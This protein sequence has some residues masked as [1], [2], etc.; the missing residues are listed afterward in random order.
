M[1][2]PEMKILVHNPE[3]K[4]EHVIGR[5]RLTKPYLLKLFKGVGLSRYHTR[6]IRFQPWQKL[7]VVFAYGLQDLFRLLMYSMAHCKDRSSVVVQ[8]EFTLLYYSFLSPFYR[9]T[10]AK[11][12]I[13][14]NRNFTYLSP[15]QVDSS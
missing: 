15:L 13:V 12:E 5:D 4:I 14:D 9:L 8:C 11:R 6:T 10:Q 7:P 2:N 3:M 1:H